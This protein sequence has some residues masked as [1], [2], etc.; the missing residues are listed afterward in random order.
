MNNV[1]PLITARELGDMIGVSEQGIKNDMRD[2]NIPSVRIGS[3]RVMTASQFAV[4]VHGL[5]VAAMAETPASA[6]EAPDDKAATV[7][8]DPNVKTGAEAAQPF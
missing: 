7:N 8:T 4:W 6:P 3:K 5:E 1:P 2:G